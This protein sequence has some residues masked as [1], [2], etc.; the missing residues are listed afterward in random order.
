MDYLISRIGA[1]VFLIRAAGNQNIPKA[2]PRSVA[3]V[4]MQIQEDFKVNASGVK[5][6]WPDDEEA[7]VMIGVLP[8]GLV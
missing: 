2:S 4:A 6:F 5:L 1:N 7:T 3:D 8:G